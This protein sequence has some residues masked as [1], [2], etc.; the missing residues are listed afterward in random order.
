MCDYVWLLSLQ[1]FTTF[2]IWADKIKKHG[3]TPKKE[4]RNN[5]HNLFWIKKVVNVKFK[6][7]EGTDVYRGT[8]IEKHCINA[9]E[10]CCFY[11]RGHFLRIQT[12]IQTQV[13]LQWGLVNR[14]IY[15]DNET[16]RGGLF[17]RNLSG[18]TWICPSQTY[19]KN[20]HIYNT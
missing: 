13:Q 16:H 12:R 20:W 15:P 4:Y 18:L 3:G 8:A 5:E 6:K 1:L 14:K 2:W 11:L 19:L 7:Y 17:V 9:E 10:D